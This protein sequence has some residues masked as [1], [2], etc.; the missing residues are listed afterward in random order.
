MEL[1]KATITLDGSEVTVDYFMV[2]AHGKQVQIEVIGIDDEEKE[3][4]AAQKVR[5]MLSRGMVVKNE[6]VE[7]T[8]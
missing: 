2:P 5:K 8:T 7:D 6:F 3:E 1:R 4:E